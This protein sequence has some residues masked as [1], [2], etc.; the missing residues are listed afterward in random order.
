MPLISRILKD[1]S[2]VTSE[3]Y[4]A[5]RFQRQILGK[6]L[7]WLGSTYTHRGVRSTNSR[8]INDGTPDPA[9]VVE[10]AAGLQTDMMTGGSQSLTKEVLKKVEGFKKG[11]LKNYS[12]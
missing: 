7:P 2:N 10:W 4:S 8:Y 9:Y 5:A 1:T 11:Y 3:P 12:K 6:V